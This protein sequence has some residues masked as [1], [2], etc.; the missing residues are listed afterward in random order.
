MSESSR[1]SPWRRLRRAVI[2]DSI[3]LA[4]QS[5]FHKLSLIAFFAWVG[6][7]ADGL[8]SSCYG[9]AEAY[10]ALG[11]HTF[12]AVFVALGTALTIFVISAAYSQIIELFPSGGG[13]YIVASSLLSPKVGMVSGCALLIDY[14][15]TITL[16]VASGADAVFSFLPASWQPW[17]LCVAIAGV[18]VFPVVRA[19]RRRL[20]SAGGGPAVPQ[21][22]RAA[23]RQNGPCLG[24]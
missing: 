4:D 13:G 10:L 7:G 3:S 15:L 14:V 24:H 21:L 20:A 5:L 18:P 6:L 16:S 1:L 19:F 17:R 2:G 12:L 22:S 8:S 11:K 23:T 9:P